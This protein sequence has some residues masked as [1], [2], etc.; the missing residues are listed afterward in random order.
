MSSSSKTT[1]TQV[2]AFDLDG[3]SVRG[4]S[5]SLFTRYLLAHSLIKKR[6][7]AELIWWGVRYKLHL[8]YRQSEAREAVFKSLQEFT[9]EDVDQLMVCFHD[10]VMV[11][12]YRP[13]ALAE[14]SRLRAE[15][16]ETLLVSATFYAIAEAAA[17]TMG[18]DA[19]LATAMERDEN[20][21]YTGLV[22]GPVLADREKYLA[23]ARWCDER[24]GKDGWELVCAYGDHYSDRD[25]LS[26][27]TN[28]CAVCPDQSL[29]KCAKKY[30]WTILDWGSVE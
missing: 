22:D 25:L 10:E 2:A 12:R 8:P 6:W 20:G 15:G 21:R 30:G 1:K 27:A 7:V 11:P 13:Q 16:V 17:C 19:F 9:A 28:P 23:V 29:K 3:T 18:V 14:V 26:H 4:Q 5:G 24:Y